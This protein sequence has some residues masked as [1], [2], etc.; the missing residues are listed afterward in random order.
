MLKTA[1]LQAPDGNAYFP[2]HEW[3]NIT[4]PRGAGIELAYAPTL[5]RRVASNQEEAVDG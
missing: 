5:E 1:V 3:V 2:D 4:G